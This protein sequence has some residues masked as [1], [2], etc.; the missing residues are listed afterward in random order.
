MTKCLYLSFPPDNNGSVT[1]RLVCHVRHDDH[2][3]PHTNVGEQLCHHLQEQVVEKQDKH[4][5][6]AAAAAEECKGIE[7]EK[8][9]AEYAVI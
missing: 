8:D 5:E 6:E 9:A 7:R 4:K 3:R 2:H 1:V